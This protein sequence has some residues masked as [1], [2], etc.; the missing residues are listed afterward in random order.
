VSGPVRIAVQ[1]SSDPMFTY[2]IWNWPLQRAMTRFVTPYGIVRA[3][4]SFLV[5]GAD[6]DALRVLR[7]K[8]RIAPAVRYLPGAVRIAM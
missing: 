8:E 1:P 6:A 2:R 5:E 3:G 7:R 4:T